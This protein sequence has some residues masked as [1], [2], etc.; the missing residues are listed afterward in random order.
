MRSYVVVIGTHRHR[1]RQYHHAQKD[2]RGLGR[3]IRPKRVVTL[4]SSR[5]TYTHKGLLTSHV[6]AP[7]LR[8]HTLNELNLT[9]PQSIPRQRKR[10]GWRAYT[11]LILADRPQFARCG[12]SATNSADCDFDRAPDTPAG[13]DPVPNLVRDNL[14]DGHPGVVLVAFVHAVSQVTKPRGRPIGGMVIN[15]VRSCCHQ[16]GRRTYVGFQCL[17]ILSLSWEI[18]ALPAYEAQLVEEGS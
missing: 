11:H 16:L 6:H 12:S 5:L 8:S 10:R 14:D 9:N 2:I 15:L 3:I 13:R 18:R 1:Y 17:A 4:Q 7:L